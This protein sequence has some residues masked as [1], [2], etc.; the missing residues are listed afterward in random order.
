MRGYLINVATED[1]TEGILFKLYDN[2]VMVLDH[3]GAMNF[4][5]LTPELYV[6]QHTLQLAYYRDALPEIESEKVQFFT[7]NFTL[8]TLSLT[9]QVELLD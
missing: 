1:S 3:I 4:E 7:A 8:P 2:D 6:G 9:F 5:Y